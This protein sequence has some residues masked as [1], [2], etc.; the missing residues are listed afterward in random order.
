VSS[1]PGDGQDARPD[2]RARFGA[3]AGIFGSVMF[4]S[5]LGLQD[6]LRPG[7]DW[8]TMPA[9]ADSLGP[10]GWIQIASFV[11]TGTCILLFAWGAAGAFPRDQASRWG[12]RLLGVL[13]LCVLGSGPFVM[14][15]PPIAPFSPGSTCHGTVHG[16]LGAIAFTLMPVCCF[17]FHHRFRKVPGWRPFAR[18][19]LATGVVIVLAIFLLKLAQLRLLPDGG[20]LFQRIALVAFFGWV[21]AFGLQVLREVQPAGPAPRSVGDAGGPR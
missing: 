16:V 10:H 21:C 4:V 7:Y 18:L 3:R 17:V 9:S 19:S 8:K 5:V 20:G 11:V 13:G 1:T 6:L 14:D 2:R 15:P 12:P